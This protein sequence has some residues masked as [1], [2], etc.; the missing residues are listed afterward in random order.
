MKNVAPL[1]AL[2]DR[3][4]PALKAVVVAGLSLAATVV[5]SLMS[6]QVDQRSLT[7]AVTG[8]ISAVVAYLVPNRE[9]PSA[10]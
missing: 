1:A 7:V 4:S 3:V 10:P 6:G 2:F 5:L 9:K 8:L